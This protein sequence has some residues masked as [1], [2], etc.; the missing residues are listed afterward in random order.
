MCDALILPKRKK[1]VLSVTNKVYQRPGLDNCESI[2]NC[3]VPS[4]NWN[5]VLVGYY[6]AVKFNFYAR[7]A[8]S[9]VGSWVVIE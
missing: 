8:A 3:Y 6:A 1:F 2:G 4:E 7:M 9:I 5:C